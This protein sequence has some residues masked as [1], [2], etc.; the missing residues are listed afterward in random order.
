MF[1]D[2]D[3]VLNAV[4]ARDGRPYPPRSL[5]DLAIYPEV[6]GSLTRLKD[7]GFALVVVTNQPD[8]ARATQTREMVEAMNAHLS[9]VLPLDEVRVCYHDDEDRCA[10]RKPSPGLLTAAPYYDL[11]GS[12]MVGDRWRDVEAGQNAGCR[13]VFIDRGYAERQPVADAHVRSLSEA[14]DWILQRNERP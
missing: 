7:A 13:T 5:T 11:P 10:C 9:T 1:L 14:V 12:F 6:P 3:G 2:R 4:I 8:V